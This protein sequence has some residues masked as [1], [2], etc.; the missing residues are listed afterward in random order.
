MAA[1]ALNNACTC[2][3]C[4]ARGFVPAMFDR[5]RKALAPSG[6]P[7]T[8]KEVARWAASQQ[9]AIVPQA[10]DGHFDLGG[11]IAGHPW[12]LECGAPTREYVRGLELRGRADVGADPDAA[13]M[14]I[15]RSLHEALES[16]AYHAITDTLQ[17]TVNASLPEEMRW[18]A[19]YEEMSWPGLPASFRQHFA[20]V[21]ERIEIAQRWI[22]AP[23]VSQLL[24]F[25][26][27][28]QSAA[29]TQS[30]LVLMLVRGRVY[31]R[32]EHTQRSLPEI[33]HATQL[34][35]VGARAALQNLPPMSVAGPEDDSAH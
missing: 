31:L 22:H 8:T 33:V 16:N 15:N 20:V 9:L 12:R 6:G 5:L 2:D 19:M 14:V 4:E 13:V 1:N 17:T 23:L 29:R 32:M 27:G 35:L 34:L 11:D 3:S 24:N 21:A 18:L 25:L 28:E 30:P 10:A 7:V 26:E